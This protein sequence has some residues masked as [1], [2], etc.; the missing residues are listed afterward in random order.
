VA[1]CVEGSAPSVLNVSPCVDNESRNVSRRTRHVS[2]GMRSAIK[3]ESCFC[4]FRLFFVL[5]FPFA[6]ARGAR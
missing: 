3:G 6:I 4:S 5:R 1:S 2:L